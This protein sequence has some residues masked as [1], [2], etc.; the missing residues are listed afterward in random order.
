MCAYVTSFGAPKRFGLN[1]YCGKWEWFK[2]KHLLYRF[3]SGHITLGN[4]IIMHVT[5][6][7]TVQRCMSQAFHEHTEMS[8]SSSFFRSF[9]L[10]WPTFGSITDI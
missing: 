8:S 6:T 9:F 2:D 10:D 5:D 1:V 7:K 4:I 3:F